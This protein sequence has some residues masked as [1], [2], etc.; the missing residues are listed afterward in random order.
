MFCCSFLLIVRIE[1]V[2]TLYRF[3]TKKTKYEYE[4]TILL[5][6]V[7]FINDLEGDDKSMYSSLFEIICYY[8]YTSMLIINLSCYLIILVTIL[9]YSIFM[10][11]ISLTGSNANV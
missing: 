8:F 4:G 9:I 1:N 6:L 7:K 10:I 3:Y 11:V 5:C 2:L